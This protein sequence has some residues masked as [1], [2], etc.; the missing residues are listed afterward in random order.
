M[1]VYAWKAQ[2]EREKEDHRLMVLML[3]Q[4]GCG[5]QGRFTA[6]TK[7]DALLEYGDLLE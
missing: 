1:P 7:K 6:T 5:Q 3:V 4:L 2:L